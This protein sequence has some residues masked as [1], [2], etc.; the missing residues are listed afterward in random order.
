MLGS[1]DYSESRGRQM[2]QVQVAAAAMIVMRR[3]VRKAET[4]KFRSHIAV[5]AIQNSSFAKRFHSDH[6]KVCKFVRRSENGDIAL[7]EQRPIVD[8]FRLIV[9]ITNQGSIYVALQQKLNKATWR[10]FSKLDM[11]ARDEFA[12][13]SDRL[14][15]ERSGNG[16]SETDS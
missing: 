2:L 4:M 12:D 10:L 5:G 7:F 13:F 11:K 9:E 3:R 8:S 6:W 1:E 16:W 15:N 14:K